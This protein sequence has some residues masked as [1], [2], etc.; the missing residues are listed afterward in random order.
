[1]GIRAGR[2]GR[3]W[4]YRVLVRSFFKLSRFLDGGRSSFVGFS[5]IPL[6]IAPASNLGAR[7]N[8]ARELG[9]IADYQGG[10]ST[11]P[12][13]RRGVYQPPHRH[14]RPTPTAR[15]PKTWVSLRTDTPP[16]RIGSWRHRYLR[17]YR[18]APRPHPPIF[19][20]DAQIAI[21]RNLCAHGGVDAKMGPLRACR[22]GGVPVS[23]MSSRV[24]AVDA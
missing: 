9:D 4:G 22:F 16:F 2:S 19:R 12:P 18:R 17:T 1:M 20:G 7:K 6:F 13:S 24:G 10:E 11:Q 23:S 21:R 14:H 5:K 15:P 3:T 8:R